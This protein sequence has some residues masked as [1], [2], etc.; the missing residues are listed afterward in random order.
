MMGSVGGL[1]FW[2]LF[3][4]LA[5]PLIDETGAIASPPA[6]STDLGPV[7]EITADHK[8]SVARVIELMGVREVYWPRPSGRLRGSPEESGDTALP[9]LARMARSA[10]QAV[11]RMALERLSEAGRPEYLDVVF[12]ALD[13]PYPE[14]RETAARCLVMFDAS[15]V[16][17][18]VM[19]M[20]C[21]RWPQAQATLADALPLLEVQ[22]ESRMVRVLEA[23]DETLARRNAAAYSLG[24]MGATSAMALLAQC[25]WSDDPALAVTSTQALGAMKAPEAVPYLAQLTQHRVWDIRW[26]A[27]DGLA[28][29]G[30]SEAIGV[31]GAIAADMSEENRPLQGRAVALLEQAPDDTAVPALIEAMRRNL[32]VRRA[33]AQALRRR[34][35]VDLGE[36]PSEWAAW[37]E[38]SQCPPEEPA[39][40]VPHEEAPPPDEDI[41]ALVPPGNRPLPT[42]PQV[43]NGVW[44]APWLDLEGNPER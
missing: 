42:M 6:Q 39:P 24:C 1:P 16:F 40:L 12:A 11:R 38:E 13:D 20:L 22:V 4:I 25:A 17:E 8:G 18:G 41:R 32:Y 35:G 7:A 34:T 29:V 9:V 30:T 5:L 14:V 44:P 43:P 33:A 27:L 2:A 26:A 21:T 3:L 19:D 31:L 23:E 15:G 28:A 10:D 36:I 37:Y